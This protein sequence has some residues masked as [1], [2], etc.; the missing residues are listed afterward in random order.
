MKIWTGNAG[1]S[2]GSAVTVFEAPV[3]SADTFCM[4]S[5]SR[6]IEHTRLLSLCIDLDLWKK[7]SMK[8]EF[9]KKV[10]KGERRKV[11]MDVMT[12]GL[13]EVCEGAWARGEMDRP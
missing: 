7:C 9:F 5:S 10:R 8:G 12:S 13:E 4:L 3:S 11:R 6:E 1:L 2:S